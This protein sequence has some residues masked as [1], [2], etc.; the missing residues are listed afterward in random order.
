[1]ISLG[2]FT[3]TIFP[4]EEGGIRFY[5]PEA[6]NQLTIDVEPSGSLY[7]HAADVEAGTFDEATI[8]A[9]NPD[10]PSALDSWLSE[11]DER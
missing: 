5:W 11:V 9:D 8:S 7:V 1:M 3:R 4:T 10:L 6:E 2:N